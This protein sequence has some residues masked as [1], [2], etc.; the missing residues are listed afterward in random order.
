MK[1]MTTKYFLA[2]FL[3]F[4]ALTTMAQEESDIVEV[5]GLI[6]TKGQSA[7]YAYVPFVTVAVKGTTRGTYANYEGMYSIVVKKG[8]TLSFSAVGFASRD[9]VIPEDIN[10]MYHTLTVEMEPTEINMEEITVFPWPDRDNLGAEF[11]AMQPNRAGQLEAIAKDNLDKKQLLAVAN[12]T[13]MDGQESS[14]QYLRQQASDYSYQ[15]Q[16]APQSIFDPIA[17]GKFFNQWK[18]KKRTAKEEQMIKILEG[19]NGN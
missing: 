10:G 2:L 3:S 5:Y 11:L 1:M 4:L 18:K 8:Q 9:I 14:I 15:G 7:Q 19:E 12:A 16:Q 13:E 17:W 6:L